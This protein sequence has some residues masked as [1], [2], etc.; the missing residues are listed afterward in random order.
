MSR[1][2]VSA[3][4]DVVAS[5][6]PS[7][8]PVEEDE[9]GAWM[10]DDPVRDDDDENDAKSVTVTGRVSRPKLLSA[11]PMLPQRPQLGSLSFVPVRGGVNS[12]QRHKN[13]GVFIKLTTR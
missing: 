6:D 9:D 8:D 7:D 5:D 1:T 12:M 2:A 3:A 11:G 13:R 4:S 10:Q